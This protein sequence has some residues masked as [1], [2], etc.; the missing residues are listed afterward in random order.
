MKL[1]CFDLRIIEDNSNFAVFC[2]NTR[3]TAKFLFLLGVMKTDRDVSGGYQIL[4]NPFSFG[5]K[6][7]I[8]K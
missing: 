3:N 4:E 2:V 5:E 1:W 8:I 7:S 6:Y